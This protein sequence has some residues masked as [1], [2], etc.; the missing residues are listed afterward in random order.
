MDITALD[1]ARSR[2]S[3][4]R[5]E[6]ERFEEGDPRTLRTRSK[7]QEDV[8]KA[9]RDL[10]HASIDVGE[11]LAVSVD[12][13]VAAGDLLNRPCVSSANNNERSP[14]RLRGAS[15]QGSDMRAGKRSDPRASDIPLNAPRVL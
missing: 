5:R 4:S 7:L 10:R 13:L 2:Q 12:D 8:E 11:R 15:N 9:E 14:E 3:W 1:R 6:L